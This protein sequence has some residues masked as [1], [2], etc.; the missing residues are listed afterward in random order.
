MDCNIKWPFRLS[1]TLR[2]CLTL[3]WS[4]FPNSGRPSICLAIKGLATALALKDYRYQ[5]IR[6]CISRGFGALRGLGPGVSAIGYSVCSDSCI[7]VNIL[8]E[9]IPFTKGPFIYDVC[10]ISGFLGSLS[11]YMHIYID[12][13]QPPMPLYICFRGARQICGCLMR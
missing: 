2:E 10:N 8:I 9:I 5:Q 1:D 4:A 3:L 13:I 12:Y 7:C 6:L 11:P